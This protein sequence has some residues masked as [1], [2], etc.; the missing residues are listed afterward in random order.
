MPRRKKKAEEEQ[1]IE[2]FV[3]QPVEEIVD[4]T[5]EEAQPTEEV[6]GTFC[7]QGYDFELPTIRKL[8]VDDTTLGLMLSGAFRPFQKYDLVVFKA[9]DRKHFALFLAFRAVVPGGM[10]L[11]RPDLA[12]LRMFRDCPQEA[13]GGMVKVQKK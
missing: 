8:T 7:S 11:V 2:Q 13:T 9:Q 3:E 1:Q 6:I 10:I 5:A 4:R 12:G